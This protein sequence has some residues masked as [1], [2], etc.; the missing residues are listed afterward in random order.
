MEQSNLKSK[1]FTG[2]VWSFIQRFST[3]LIQFISGI[4][5]ARL[6]DPEDYGCIGMLTIFMLLA[7]AILDGGFGAALVQKKRPSQN[8]YSTIFWWNVFISIVLYVLLFFSSP[9]IATYYHIEALS[10]VLRV[11]SL[12]LII[13]SMQLVHVNKLTKEFKFKLI[14]VANLVAAIISLTATTVLAYYGF[15]VWALVAQTLLL[16]LIPTIIYWMK[17]SWKPSFIFSKLS[18]KELFGFGF[19]MLLT[20]LVQTLVNNVQGL[21]IGRLYN[22]STMGYYSKAQSTEM[23][24]STSLAQVITQ[25]SYPIY[26]ELQDN[27]QGLI[28]AIKKLTSVVAFVTFPLMLILLLLAEPIFVLLYSDKWLSSV[29]YFQ[30]LCIAGL[31]I[32]LQSV[33]VQSIAAIGKSKIMFKWGLI[34]QL[35]GLCLML[36]GL[37]LYGIIGLLVGMVMKSWLIYIINASLV[38]VHIGYKLRKQFTDLMPILLVAVLAMAISYICS[39]F[40]DRNTY[41]TALIE[42]LIYLAVYATISFLAKLSAVSVFWEVTKP[43]VEKVF[44]LKK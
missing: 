2:V 40:L 30:V 8:D 31:A 11:Q 20:N 12:V 26:S 4:V 44:K 1:A 19:Y 27:N 13:N 23:L 43:Y 33:N 15:G 22:S 25:V 7:S 29:P 17:T 28:N 21:L 24:A 9:Y 16:A 36:I 14:S 34:K 3:I 10:S 41:F 38:S 35:G 39:L 32:C 37:Y 42:L 6:L 5:L 18:F